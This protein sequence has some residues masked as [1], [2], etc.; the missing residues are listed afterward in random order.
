MAISTRSR[1]SA[2]RPAATRRSSIACRGTTTRFTP[3]R[4]LRHGRGW[5]ALSCMD[6]A[7]L[8]SP[9]VRY[10]MSPA[11]APFSRRCRRGLPGRCGPGIASR[12]ICTSPTPRRSRSPSAAETTPKCSPPVRPPIDTEADLVAGT[13]KDSGGQSVR[14]TTRGRNFTVG[15]SPR[16]LRALTPKVIRNSHQRSS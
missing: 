8:A 15:S 4:L 6:C 3:T 10:S 14:S 5:T 12:S 11:S 7:P 13:S 16:P 1:R 2:T 9:P